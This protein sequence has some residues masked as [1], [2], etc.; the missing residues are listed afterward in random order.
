[1]A[2]RPRKKMPVEQR[3]KQFMPFAALKGLPEALAEKEKIIVPRVELSE[4]MAEELD[5]KM[6]QL[7]KG[8]MAAVVYFAEGEY[9][10]KTG[11]VARVEET[12]RYLQIV[13]TKISFEDV[14]DVK[15]ES[16][17]ENGCQIPDSGL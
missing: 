1:M 17:E 2:A 12:A 8:K 13:D 7:E 14:L 3:A 9:L 16:T 5:F 4:E 10:K 6:H 15:V 11:V